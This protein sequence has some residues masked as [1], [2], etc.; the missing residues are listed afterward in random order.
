VV[1]IEAIVGE[2]AELAH[3]NS[4]RG[5]FIRCRVVVPGGP[6]AEQRRLNIWLPSREA[7]GLSLGTRVRVMVEVL[8]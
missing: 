5:A 3:H 2:V 4:V 6:E 1:R 7:V 8:P